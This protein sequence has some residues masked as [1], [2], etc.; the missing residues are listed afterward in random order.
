MKNA[1]L[2]V[3]IFCLIHAGASGQVDAE[4]AADHVIIKYSP[5]P[6]FDFDNTIQFGVEIPFGQSG[7][8]LQQDLGYGRSTFNAWYTEQTN[9]P[10]KSTYK[11]RTTLRYYYFG[12]RRVRGYVAGEFMFKQ[13]VYRENQWVGMDCSGF[14]GCGYFE[15]KDIR[16]A[17]IVGAGHAKMGWQFYFPSRLT[18]DLFAGLG[19]RSIKVRTLTPGLDNAL[20]RG[21]DEFWAESTPGTREIV[22]SLV[23]GFH[24]GFVLGKFED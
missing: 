15:N 19:M 21:P 3:L 1:L 14:G 16:I 10:D 23:L 9:V 4:T 18:M 5:L 12:K 6:M 2:Y 11:S 22:P 7:V 17:R 24:L 13:V 20:I 8:T